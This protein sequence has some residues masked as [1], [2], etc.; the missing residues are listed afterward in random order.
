MFGKFS[1]KGGVHPSHCKDQTASL[2]IE[3]LPAP[4]KVIIPL[5]QH[6]GAPAKIAVKR[7]DMVKIGQVLG[8]AGGFVSAPVHASVSG[9]VVSVGPFAH[10]LGKQVTA[11]E[12]ENDGNDDT[13]EFTPLPTPWREAAPQEIVQ[14]ISAA[15]IVGMG[16]AS[17]PTHV[18]LSPPSNKPIDTVI[19]NGAECEPY[20]TADHRLMLEK[21]E[22]MLCGAMIIKKIL[23]ASKIWIGIEENKPDAIAVISEK[24]AQ[25]KFKEISLAKLKAKYPQGGEKQ[26]INAVTKRQV[27][28]GGLPMDCG[29]VVQNIG[30]AYTIW[31]AVCNGKPLYQRV[32]TV[33]GSTIRKPA[34]LLVRIGTPIKTLL[35]HCDID[36]DSTQKVIMGGPMMG[37]AQSDFTAPVIKSTSG[38]LGYK[39]LTTGV[40]EYDCISCGNCVKACPIHLVPSYLAK[41]VQKGLYEDAMTWNILDCM[42]CGS[43][44]YACPSKINLVHYMKV[45]KFHAMG[46]KKE[47]EKK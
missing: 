42:E 1:F 47:K 32:V 11:V 10:P 14:K 20:L 16:G 38:I 13:V 3:T 35:E 27:P 6:I 30:T 17:F 19:I 2:N 46:I 45:G 7:D 34:N 12:I 23:G 15:G 8:E 21:T 31:D 22:E 40:R 28:S 25:D 24:I 44:A 5:S 9:K 33:T 18:K 26:L 39:T 43:C 4:E 41:Y 36:Y 29:C 37:L